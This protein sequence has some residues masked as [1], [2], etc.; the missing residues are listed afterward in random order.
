MHG[1]QEQIVDTQRELYF[2]KNFRDGMN[3]YQMLEYGIPKRGVFFKKDD[4]FPQHLEQ[5]KE[6]VVSF[7]V[8]D[9][10]E[11]P[12]GMIMI[13]NQDLCLKYMSLILR[14]VYM[15]RRIIHCGTAFELESQCRDRDQM[16]YLSK[17]VSLLGVYSFPF[18]I[19][20]VLKE[21]QDA[22]MTPF[23]QMLSTRINNFLPTILVCHTDLM[24]LI[25][26]YSSFPSYMKEDLQNYFLVRDFQTSEGIH[27]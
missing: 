23:H 6:Y 27:K 7:T 22:M 5:I 21:K 25:N 10:K 2:Q 19:H 4:V 8:G 15:R 18:L 12:K 11:N 13:G 20:G 17:E 16:N 24:S 3:E 1:Q 9:R 14:R 26:I